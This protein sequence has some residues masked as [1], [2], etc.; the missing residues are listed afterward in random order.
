[1]NKPVIYLLLLISSFS[2]ILGDDY[3]SNFDNFKSEACQS[4]QLADSSKICVYVNNQCKEQLADCNLY[5]GSDQ[6]ECEAI[7]PK[8][9]YSKC[10]F[11]NNQCQSE[12]KTSCSD[13][14]SGLP[15]SYCDNIQISNGGQCHLVNNECKER[16]YDC[17]QYTGNDQKTC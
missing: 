7:I 13:Y 15:S 11:K 9:S 14:K 8:F 3:C 1:M 16:Y 12:E 2:F 5:T 10:V 4:V 17:T 6:S